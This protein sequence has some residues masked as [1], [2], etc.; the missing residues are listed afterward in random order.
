VPVPPR[1]VPFDADLGPDARGATVAVYSRCR[2]RPARPPTVPS[3][4]CT[5]RAKA[6]TC[7]AST[8]PQGVSRR[9]PR[10]TRPG[11]TEFWPTIWKGALAFARTYDA[12]PDYPY[13]YTRPVTG[14]ADLHAHAGRPAQGVRPAIA[15]RVHHEPARTAVSRAR[16]RSSCTAGARFRVDLCG[17]GEGLANEIRLTRSAAA[18][19]R[20]A[21]AGLTAA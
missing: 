12:K 6:A 18:H 11:A 16:P 10:P 3:P 20:V 14:R 15:A 2:N 9:S 8:S 19:T 4:R 5:A 21:A 1:A 17:L 7:T 13:I